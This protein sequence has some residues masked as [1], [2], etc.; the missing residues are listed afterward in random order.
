MDGIK[1]FENHEEARQEASEMVGYSHVEVMS[2]DFGVI[3]E[4]CD[5]RVQYYIST[6]QGTLRKDGYVK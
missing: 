4:E 6:E 3:A 2:H 5:N 1:Y